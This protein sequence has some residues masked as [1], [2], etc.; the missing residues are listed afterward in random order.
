[1]EE[2]RQLIEQFALNNE[3]FYEK[4]RKANYQIAA[5]RQDQIASQNQSEITVWQRGRCRWF[6]PERGYGFVTP[7]DGSPDLFLHR[8]AFPRSLALVL[9]PG[10]K[11][12]FKSTPDNPSHRITC[13]RGIRRRKRRGGRRRLC[14]LCNSPEHL[15]RA[16]TL[17]VP[18]EN[19]NHL[20]KSQT[21]TVRQE[22]LSPGQKDITSFHLSVPSAEQTHQRDE[23]E[24]PPAPVEK[25]ESSDDVNT[26]VHYTF[27]TM[28]PGV[29]TAEVAVETLENLCGTPVPQ[30]DDDGPLSVATQTTGPLTR[31]AGAIFAAA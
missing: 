8:S 28:L 27:F 30:C 20:A 21:P 19:S 16:C 7:D 10:F 23:P 13:L 14:W 5:W 29:Q 15:A 18:R 11:V 31:S 12:K 2:L 26:Y 9:R 25:I 3:K 24:T 22:L 17:K 6:D 4:I 1:M